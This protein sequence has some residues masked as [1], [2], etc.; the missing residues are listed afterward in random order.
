MCFDVLLNLLDLIYLVSILPEPPNF[1]DEILFKGEKVIA[2][3]F[4]LRIKTILLNFIRLILLTWLSNNPICVI[5]FYNEL[6]FLDLIM[7]LSA[8]SFIC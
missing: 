6:L 5:L 8:L 7:I 3:L 1:E 2:R 4:K